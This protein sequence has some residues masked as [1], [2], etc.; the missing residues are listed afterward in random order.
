MSEL[1]VWW[2][3][4]NPKWYNPCTCGKIS[5]SRIYFGMEHVTDNYQSPVIKE[6]VALTTAVLWMF[7]RFTFASGVLEMPCEPALL[8]EHM[9]LIEEVLLA[10]HQKPPVEEIQSWR[11]IVATKLAEGAVAR[12]PMRLVFRYEPFDPLG[13][14]TEGFQL[15]IALRAGE[16]ISPNSRDTNATVEK[17]DARSRFERLAVARGELRMPCLPSLVERH[18][19]QMEM[20][21]CALRQNLTPTEIDSWRQ[22]IA[23][24]VA[25]WFAASPNTY[26]SVRYEM[27][28]PAFGLH[29]GVKLNLGRAVS[30]IEDHY[31]RWSQRR[32]GTLFGTHA[33]AKVLATAAQLGAPSSAPIL[34]VGA[35]NGRNS[36]A[37][38]RQGY[39]VDAIELTQVLADQLLEAAATEGIR[40]N[41]IQGDI[42]APQLALKSAHY[43]LAVLSE[44]IA[45]HFRS[46]AQVR[47]LMMRMSQAIA[48]GGF[49]LFNLFLT[50]DDYKPN[51]IV[52]EI[53]QFCWCY[54]LT[55]AELR[56]AMEGL[57]WEM[58]S[59]E[60]V[61]DYERRH[62][63]PQ[64]WP[65]TFWFVKW[66]TGRNLFPIEQT[67]PVELRWILC[68]RQDKSDSS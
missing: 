53:S 43:K 22:A 4:P 56:A 24:K 44:V 64:A 35:G 59:D 30:S 65:P 33:D 34:D 29:G 54:V 9:W 20:L 19:H 1:K 57:P 47:Q 18:L 48:P 60:S 25:Q 52:R 23:P 17:L 40:V 42:L 67:P 32:E 55:R 5:L 63:P 21:L 6:P 13:G 15:R 39:P 7:K 38:A 50:V 49:L 36:L 8:D 16:D 37:L 31:R 12:A 10:L 11:Q 14:L 68:Q 3:F 45:S 41:V 28:E 66:S 62:L 51:D 61:F 26:L 2:A 27:A 46:P 58:L